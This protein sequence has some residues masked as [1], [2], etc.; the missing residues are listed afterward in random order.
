MEYELS[1]K[2]D[3]LRLKAMKPQCKYL[4]RRPS[5]EDNPPEHILVRPLGCEGCVRWKFYLSQSPL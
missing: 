5:I 3:R 1:W 4:I 2:C